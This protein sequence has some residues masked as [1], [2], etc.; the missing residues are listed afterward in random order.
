MA[1][2]SL[3]DVPEALAEPPRRRSLPLIWLLP[4]IAALVGGWLAVKT[5][6]E[7]GPTITI[8]FRTA[9]GLEAG[10]T[11]IRVRDVEIGAVTAISLGEDLSSVVVTAE[12]AKS[13]EGFLVEDTRFWVVRPRISGGGISGIGTVLSGAYI[14]VDHG[15][16]TVARRHF[17]GL[18]TPPVLTTGLPGSEFVLRADD[19]GSISHGT[20]VYFRKLEVGEVVAYTL[21]DDGSG[22]SIRVFVNAPYDRFVN[23]GTRFWQTSGIEVALDASGF[24]IQ[25]E[26]VAAIL[27]GGVAFGAPP[28]AAPAVPAQAGT[29]FMLHAT[30]AA[31][32]R[33]EGT[34]R[35]RYLAVFN[36]SVR[37]LEVGAPVDFRGI[38]IGEVASIQIDT[39][40]A[41]RGADMAVELRIFPDRMRRMLRSRKDRVASPT[42]EQMREQ[43]DELVAAGLRAQLRTGNL[44]TGQLYVALD[45]FPNAPR[46]KVDWANSPPTLPTTAGGLQELQTTLTSLASK[47][48]KIPYQQV[49][50]D[51]R[52]ALRSLDRTLGD[53][54]TLVK[55][56]NAELAPELTAALADARKTFAVAQQT[57]ATAERTLAAAQRALD[58][59]SPLQ[60]EVREAL[61]EVSRAAAS[62]RALTDALEREPQ[63]LIR[64]RREEK[65][66]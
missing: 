38:V 51:L 21:D 31:A 24:R 42:D 14:G 57:L 20:P 50:A 13:A 36:E 49:A 66:P 25:T 54:D 2:T 45:F 12:L 40:G 53:A 44:L 61:R 41:Q 59:E 11:K 18:E 1:E 30:R 63:S 56:L 3:P 32:F 9:E 48:E 6:L 55:R 29:E 17:T 28:D 35:Q 37:G 34:R 64:G 60:T 4:A 65:T 47:L 15:K 19:L 5:I 58:S 39:A 46:A 22:F 10:K 43:V 62:V 16:S 26:S 8:T 27:V 52:Q 7:K 23:V 33:F